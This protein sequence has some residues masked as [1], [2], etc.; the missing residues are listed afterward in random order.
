MMLNHCDTRLATVN[1]RH[2]TGLTGA[3][4]RR[5]ILTVFRIKFAFAIQHP[6]ST[7]HDRVVVPRRLKRRRC[8][9][10]WQLRHGKRH[11]AIGR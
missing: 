11:F 3:L 4:L 7:L 5:R 2:D 8:R 1:T 10:F 9:L 6:S